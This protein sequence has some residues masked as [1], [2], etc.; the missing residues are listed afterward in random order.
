MD[1]KLYKSAIQKTLLNYPGLDIRAGSVFDL[2]F[3]SDPPLQLHG[4]PH[5][6]TEAIRKIRGVRLGRCGLRT[7]QVDLLI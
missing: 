3:D 7:L 4:V 2:D 1:R 6:T 5:P